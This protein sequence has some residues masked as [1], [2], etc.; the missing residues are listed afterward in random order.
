[1]V[2]AKLAK[3]GQGQ[4]ADRVDPQIYGTTQTQAAQLLNVSERT[5]NSN[6]AR[7]IWGHFMGRVESLQVEYSRP[8][9]KLRFV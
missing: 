8:P 3:L 4:R 5:V 9:G 6:Q 2:A 1:M 7:F